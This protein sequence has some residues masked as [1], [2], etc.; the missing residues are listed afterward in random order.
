MRHY[1]GFWQI[2]SHMDY[3][4]LEIKVFS[5]RD[6]LKSFCP[7]EVGLSDEPCTQQFYPLYSFEYMD[8]PHLNFL[9]S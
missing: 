5:S 7:L 6:P 1:V 4:I 3:G 2:G 9:E 8:L